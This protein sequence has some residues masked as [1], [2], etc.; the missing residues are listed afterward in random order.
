[1]TQLDA[2]VACMGGFFLKCDV[3]CVSDRSKHF[4]LDYSADVWLT[5]VKVD[6]WSAQTVSLAWDNTVPSFMIIGLII[7][8]KCNSSYIHCSDKLQSNLRFSGFFVIDK[9]RL[10]I[11][12]KRFT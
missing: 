7:A 5:Y 9:T 3:Q 11:I 12:E 4:H 8:Q 6:V 10:Q 2:G 1:M